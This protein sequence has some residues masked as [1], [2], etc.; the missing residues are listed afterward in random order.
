MR[1]LTLDTLLIDDSLNKSLSNTSLKKLA[2][3]KCQFDSNYHITFNMKSIESLYIFQCEKCPTLLKTIYSSIRKSK[4]LYQLEI[5]DT[6]YDH[7]YLYLILRDTSCQKLRLEFESF[8]T[9]LFDQTKLNEYK[10][11][12]KSLI[13]ISSN[14]QPHE[15]LSF[16]K[17]NPQLEEL[18]LS[19]NI[20]EDLFNI[21]K[22]FTKLKSF[23]FQYA[24][25]DY[26]A[27][28][29]RII[30]IEELKIDS[31]NTI[32]NKNFQKVLENN[33]NLKSLEMS[34]NL[35]SGMYYF[36]PIISFKYLERLTIHFCTSLDTDLK[37][38]LKGLTK[39]K[40]LKY[41][42]IE[43]YDHRFRFFKNF[44]LEN[45][46]LEVLILSNTKNDDI[47]DIFKGLK[48]NKFVKRCIIE[49]YP[50][51]VEYDS[52]IHDLF[53]QNFTLTDLKISKKSFDDSNYHIEKIGKDLIKKYCRRNQKMRK[54]YQ[55]FTIE[56]DINFQFD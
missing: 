51:I 35:Q 50:R 7:K 39:S 27:K 44:L 22:E 1:E 46:S 41:L 15:T 36:N 12:L 21:L 54:I 29:L 45:T 42:N 37:K 53:Q 32:L 2:F 56:T 47:K 9:K 28:L 14:K 10:F 3:I 17:A 11:H 52:E 18:N 40:T 23:S 34:M 49:F 19:V 26:V 16:I 43:L 4:N 30:P 33:Q 25:F 55:S 31:L 13:I 24:D 38:F 48:V 6:K 20:N 8:V 5:K